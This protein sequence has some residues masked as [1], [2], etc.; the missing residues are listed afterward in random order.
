M[1]QINLKRSCVRQIFNYFCRKEGLM[2]KQIDE[3]GSKIELVRIQLRI[4]RGQQIKLHDLADRM[5]KPVS[6]LIRNMVD[7]GLKIR[8]EYI[9][10]GS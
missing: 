7:Q 5:K 6:E 10:A 4:T 8:E 3:H 9:T 2:P 1:F